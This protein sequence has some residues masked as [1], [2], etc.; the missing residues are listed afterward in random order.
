EEVVL[1][2]EEV[3]L[4]RVQALDRLVVDGEV[5]DDEQVA[6]LGVLVDLR[7]LAPREDVLDVERVPAVALGQEPRFLGRR[8]VE[9]NPGQ[10]VRAL[11]GDPRLRRWK[12]LPCGRAWRLAPDPGQAGHRY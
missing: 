10:P 8:R 2:D 7:P 9:M 12:S 5:E 4:R 11:L 3:E 1:V 6:V